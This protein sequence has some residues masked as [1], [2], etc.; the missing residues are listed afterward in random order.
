M[1][2]FKSTSPLYAKPTRCS[3]L[4][5]YIDKNFYKLIIYDVQVHTIHNLLIYIQERFIDL[6][7]KQETSEN[8][9]ECEDYDL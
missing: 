2:T 3:I 6:K 1:L 8:K 9:C 5:C 7:G 4:G